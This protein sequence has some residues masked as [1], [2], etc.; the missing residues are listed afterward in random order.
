MYQ[1]EEKGMKIRNHGFSRFLIKV[2]YLNFLIE[3]YF[4]G[5]GIPKV[6]FRRPGTEKSIWLDI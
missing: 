2:K 4:M 6:P 3:L 5:I 1:I